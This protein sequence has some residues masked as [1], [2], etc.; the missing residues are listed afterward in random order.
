M[1]KLFSDNCGSQTSSSP[2]R[3]VRIQL[4]LVQPRALDNI[5]VERPWRSVKHEDVYLK[6]YATV[7]ELLLGLTE[8]FVFY[9]TQRTHQSTVPVRLHNVSSE[10]RSIHPSTCIGIFRGISLSFI[11]KLAWVYFSNQIGPKKISIEIIARNL[12]LITYFIDSLSQ[13]SIALVWDILHNGS[14]VQR[15]EAHLKYR[16]LRVAWADFP[17]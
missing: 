5:F 2:A 16:R 1:E 11:A 3:T 14:F 8:Y 10:G 7:P 4:A 12:L 17:C 15:S 6:G 9:N 13:S